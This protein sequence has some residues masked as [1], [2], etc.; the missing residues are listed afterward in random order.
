MGQTHILD[1]QSVIFRWNNATPAAIE[2]EP[3]DTVVF[4]TPEITR[5][6]FTQTS[7]AAQWWTVADLRVYG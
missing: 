5:G 1:K 4:E 3:G 2:I 6:Q 7:T